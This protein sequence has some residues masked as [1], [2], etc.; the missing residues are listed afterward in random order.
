[1]ALLLGVFVALGMGLSA[2]QANDMAIKMT[3][4]SDM[5]GCDGCGGGDDDDRIGGACS[6]VCTTPAQAILAPAFPVI[7][8]AA[9]KL[10]LPDYW[11]VHG[12]VLSPDPN[13]PKPLDLG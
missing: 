3:M 5:G 6:S 9:P 4:S 11:P 7:A 10:F 13:P 8:A 12:L 2:V 1:M